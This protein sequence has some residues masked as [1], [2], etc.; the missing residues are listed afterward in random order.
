VDF[1][2]FVILANFAIGTSS[3]R[4]AADAIR[5]YRREA[6]SP[7]D[8]AASKRLPPRR[9]LGLVLAAAIA[10][11][12]HA[13]AAG[14]QPARDTPVSARPTSGT[15][16]I[17]G[18]VI[19]AATG[20]A[21]PRARVRLEGLRDAPPPVGTDDTGAF[22]FT[23]V[24]PCAC[25]V[26]VEK[27]GYMASRYPDAAPTF[28]R[29]SRTLTIG[30][31]TAV[32]DITVPLY[33]GGSISGRVVDAYGDPVVSARVQVLRAQGA[34]Q[35]ARAARG[36]G[37]R[38]DDRGEFRVARLQPG[39]YLLF[40]DHRNPADD[41]IEQQPVPT[42]YPGVV[43]A[44]QAQPIVLA[45]GDSVAGID[46]ALLAGTTAWVTG[47][48]LDEEGARVSRGRGVAATARRIGH[49]LVDYSEFPVDL[50]D[51]GGLRARLPPGDYEIEVRRSLPRGGPDGERV[52]TTRVAVN[53]TPIG[54]VTVQLGPGATMTGRIV[55]VGAEPPVRPARDVLSAAFAA[56]PGGACRAGGAPAARGRRRSVEV[57]ENWTIRLAGIFGTCIAAM[58]ARNLGSWAVTA[59]FVD[60]RDVLDRP[61]AFE[62]G[63]ILRDVRVVLSDRRTRVALQVTD[64]RGVPTRE[65]V[66]LLF[67]VD[68]TR[69]HAQSRYIRTVVPATESAG[70]DP[71]PPGG[72]GTI[73]PAAAPADAVQGLPPGEYYA[74]AIDDMPFDAPRD[75]ETLDRL[76]RSATRL[77]LDAGEPGSIALQRYSFEDLIRP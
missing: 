17:V 16:R 10:I 2:I 26:S 50:D 75:P 11:A 44:A 57:E 58:D 47:T 76:A 24:P 59:L 52:G 49:A 39:R 72:A 33:R 14:A 48:V 64:E 35:A 38:T 74:V 65:Y 4:G 63:Q 69:W 62:P 34:G 15:G 55:F 32:T 68:R 73:S 8:P 43:D 28:R 56:P 9:A 22:A 6:R 36:G 31:G 45:R 37:A 53:G 51:E 41:P 70:P 61:I 7:L 18:H 29:R 67:P 71:V 20:Q 27:A 1:A 13:P 23:G 3:P 77:V 12:L 19:D 60:D 42:Y 25:S 21:V 66:G 46:I 30:A 54:N 40:V 5:V